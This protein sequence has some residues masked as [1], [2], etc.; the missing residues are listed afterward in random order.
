MSDVLLRP[1]VA[2]DLPAVAEVYVAARAAAVPALPPEL[3]SAD[4]VRAWVARWDLHADEVW[5]AERDRLLGFAHLTDTWLDGLYIDPS[6]QRIGIGSALLDVT[7]ARRPD[8]FGLWVFES[9]TP[10]RSFYRQRG[11][12]EVERTDG[13]GNEE[14]APDIKMAW[15]GSD[16][17]SF[18]GRLVEEI[19]TKIGDLRAR[20][21][22][23][24]RAIDERA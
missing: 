2:A 4:E 10:A 23:L 5:L 8:G 9:N 13:A 18:L 20:R 22:A 3:H 19:D 15:P 24:T 17:V 11:L 12:V 7:K 1:A 21:E 16:P 6:A 14:K